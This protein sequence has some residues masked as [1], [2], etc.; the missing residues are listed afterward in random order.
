M[1]ELK[2]Y[3]LNRGFK[4]IKEEI[5]FLKHQEPTIVSKLIYYN[6]IY[7][8]ETKKPYSAKPIKKYLNDELRKLKRYFDRYFCTLQYGRQ[9]HQQVVQI[10]KKII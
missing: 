8:I 4:S 2:E 9:F 6:G 7:K 10:I 1:S 5:Y 3:I